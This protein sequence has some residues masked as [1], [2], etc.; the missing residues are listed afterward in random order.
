M[1]GAPG[2]QAKA[3][4]QEKQRQGSVLQ[5]FLHQAASN[6]GAMAAVAQMMQ[7]HSHYAR[8]A[9]FATE[10]PWRTL[11][12]PKA[13]Q[14]FQDWVRSNGIPNEH[15]GPT[16]DYDM[17]GFW[18]ALQRRDPRA[19]TAINP[20]DKLPHFPDVWKTPF[21]QSFSAESMYATPNNPFKWGGADGQALLDTRNNSIIYQE[22]KK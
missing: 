22:Q 11:L 14:Q 10:G 19:L 18:Q 1:I 16:T 5:D 6:P 4:S 9:P 7:A 21:H 13:E 2:A 3:Q 15:D 17:R 8:N 20:V 12:D